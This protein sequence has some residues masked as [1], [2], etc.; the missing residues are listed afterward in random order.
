ME[1]SGPK[2]LSTVKKMI[3]FCRTRICGAMLLFCLEITAPYCEVQTEM[4]VWQLN[5][6]VKLLMNLKFPAGTR[7]A[8]TSDHPRISGVGRW[9]KS[10]FAIFLQHYFTKH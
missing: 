4:C 7:R 8:M 3:V 10:K 2:R 5:S 1:L 9:T 6:C